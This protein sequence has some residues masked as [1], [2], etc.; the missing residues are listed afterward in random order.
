VHG[1]EVCMA[2]LIVLLVIG[3]VLRTMGALGV[4]RF[5]SLREVTA[6]ALAVMFLFTASAHFTAM[7]HDLAAMI[8][9]P[10][11]GQLWVIYATGILEIA[12]AAGLLVP[13][14]RRLAALGLI[15]LLAG[16]VPANVY[17]ALEGVQLRGQ[18]PAPLLFR[19][20]LQLFWMWLLWWS[21][22]P[23]RDTPP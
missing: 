19:V 16:L 21:T 8:P 15:V 12:G 10:L 4:Q 1:Y 6:T 17:A 9:P 23:A 2:P 22:R 3:L 13:R 20:P 18:D 14:L 11:T 5:R 7:K